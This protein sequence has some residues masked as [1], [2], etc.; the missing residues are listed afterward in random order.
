VGEE[1]GAEEGEGHSD[2][3]SKKRK[4]SN[5]RRGK[6]VVMGEGKRRNWW[7]KEIEGKKV[8]GNI[9]DAGQEEW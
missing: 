7:S 4:D 8:L 1:E 5:A 9:I 3:G 6:R 2:E